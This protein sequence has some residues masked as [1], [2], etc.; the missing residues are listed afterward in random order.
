[1]KLRYWIL[2][3]LFLSPLAFAD[4]YQSNQS[5]NSVSASAAVW[6][7]NTRPGAILSKVIVSSR[8][9]GNE[10][11]SIYDSS[12]TA[13]GIIGVIDLSSSTFNTWNVYDY[14]H[15]VSSGITVSKNGASGSVIIL[16]KKVR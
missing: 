10:T 1:M 11:I 5:T 12:G 13:T 4:D 7:P 8:S 14:N 3:F 15:R 9:I 2:T 16:W 6:I